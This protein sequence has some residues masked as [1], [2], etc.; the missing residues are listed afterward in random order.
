M[1]KPK[2][3]QS[4]ESRLR[5]LLVCSHPVQYATPIFRLLTK[6]PRVEIQVAYCSMLGAESHVDPDFG[7]EVKWDI[8][9]L[10]GYRW[11]ALPNY[12]PLRHA[13]SFF[14]Y[15]NP[16]IWRSIRSGDFDAVVLHTGYVCATSWI[17][18]LAAKWSRVAVLLS[19]DAHS[20]SARDHKKWKVWIKKL[21]WPYLFG[22]ADVVIVP[23]TG[24]V[25]LMS[26]LGIPE[27]RVALTPYPVD[28][29]W[30]TEQSMR[31]DRAE[32]RAR[33]GIPQEAVIVLFSAK[34]QPWKRPLDLLRAFARVKVSDA[35]L[36]F[37]GDGSLR[38][39]LESEATSLGIWSRVHFLGFVN[40]SKLPEVYT[41]SDILVLPSEYEPF[42]VVVNEAMLCGCCV[43]V[44]D[45]VGARFDLIRENETGFVFRV[46]DAKSLAEVLDDLLRTPARLRQVRE[47]ARERIRTW[48]PDQNV[49]M[50]VKAFEKAVANARR[51]GGGAQS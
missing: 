25:T 32:V 29:V 37:V 9:L 47:A 4:I 51:R 3:R 12:S 17:A 49:E 19:T 2:G 46:G 40:Q 23:S 50:T 30:W 45:R 6:D 21:L 44:S 15:V 27:S 8:P 42:G 5:V 13:G 22:L 28:N 34:L 16:Q 35:H 11:V 7:V 48:G 39:T 10:D 26:S 33:W 18:M 14:T 43:V 41:A 20:F 1:N 24:G 31:V 38:A 36:I